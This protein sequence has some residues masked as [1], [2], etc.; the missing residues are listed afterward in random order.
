MSYS[1][2]VVV[3]LPLS[4]VVVFVLVIN[5][6]T[7]YHV[8]LLSFAFHS[9]VRSFIR[10]LVC[11]SFPVTQ[12]NDMKIQTNK[13]TKKKKNEDE[14]THLF[15][16][17][18]KS[19]EKFVMSTSSRMITKLCKLKDRHQTKVMEESVLVVSV[20]IHKCTICCG[21]QLFHIR[22]FKSAFS[23]APFILYILYLFWFLC[24]FVELQR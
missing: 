22:Y 7:V 23:I 8:T 11:F 17:H 3:R 1:F 10:S 13:H 6:C 21:N 18:S 12:T 9:I 16:E 14:I 19:L 5:N 2:L 15:M 20:K 24:V 4:G